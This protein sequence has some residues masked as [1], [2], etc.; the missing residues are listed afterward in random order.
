MR[1]PLWELNS[2]D[3]RLRSTSPTLHFSF[4]STFSLILNS[5]LKLNASCNLKINQVNSSL[6]SLLR[7]RLIGQ[8]VKHG[9]RSD[10]YQ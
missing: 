9:R 6:I 2:G 4:F 1:R 10:F 8:D 3:V 5:F 7:C